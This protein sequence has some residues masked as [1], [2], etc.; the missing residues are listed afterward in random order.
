MHLRYIQIF[1]VSPLTLP[2]RKTSKIPAIASIENKDNSTSK[3][4][5][6]D[7]IIP[8]L[9]RMKVINDITVITGI[10]SEGFR[11]LSI[12]TRIIG[13]I[14]AVPVKLVRANKTKC[15]VLMMEKMSAKTPKKKI[16]IRVIKTAF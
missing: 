10:R 8:V 9:A 16:K 1:G 11:E 15:S 13:P 5:I 12:P 14:M 2:K 4:P 6:L 3:A 7:G